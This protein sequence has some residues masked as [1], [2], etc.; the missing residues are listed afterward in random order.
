MISRRPA[1]NS[2]AANV[3]ARCISAQRRLK[4]SKTATEGPRYL[5]RGRINT[6]VMEVENV[7]DGTGESN[8]I[9]FPFL[10]FP[11]LSLFLPFL[12][13]QPP[14]NSLLLELLHRVSATA[15][16]AALTYVNAPQRLLVCLGP[17]LIITSYFFRGPSLVSPPVHRNGK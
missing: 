6:E 16:A 8:K 5:F 13:Q 1:R 10:F 9:S 3:C 17:T 12:F 15:R 7:D 2:T 14:E 4:N 11:F